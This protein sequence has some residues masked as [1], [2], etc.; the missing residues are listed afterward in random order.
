[1]AVMESRPDL[2]FGVPAAI[3]RWEILP[4]FVVAGFAMFAILWVMSVRQARAG[5]PGLA[6]GFLYLIGGALIFEFFLRWNML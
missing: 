3:T 2:V 5:W 6:F 4:N 1:M